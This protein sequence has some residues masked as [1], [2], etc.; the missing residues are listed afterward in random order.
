[1]ISIAVENFG[2]KFVRFSVYSRVGLA[3]YFFSNFLQIGWF[4]G[5]SWFALVRP[6]ALKIK[7][8]TRDDWQVAGAEA[9]GDPPIVGLR[10]AVLMTHTRLEFG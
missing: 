7:Y 5:A 9:T 8:L 4:L 6:G 2:W 10:F 3:A 1:M